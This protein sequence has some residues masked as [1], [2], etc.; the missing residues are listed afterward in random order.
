MG[1]GGTNAQIALNRAGN[2]ALNRVE[3]EGMLALEIGRGAHGRVCEYAGWMWERQDKL[4][5]RAALEEVPV[6]EE[7]LEAWLRVARWLR[8]K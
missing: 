5:L 4:R 6:A 7:K 8:G 2:V 3:V 1:T